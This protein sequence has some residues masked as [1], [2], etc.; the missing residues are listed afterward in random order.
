MQ[1]LRDAGSQ[2]S[3]AILAAFAVTDEV[4]ADAEVNVITA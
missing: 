3:D 1:D 2:W 4:C